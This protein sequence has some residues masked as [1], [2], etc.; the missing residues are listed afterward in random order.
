MGNRGIVFVASI[1]LLA[2]AGCATHQGTHSVARSTESDVR[3]I[4]RDSSAVAIDLP[5]QTGAYVLH[6][7]AKIASAAI[8]RLRGEP[9]VVLVEPLDSQSTK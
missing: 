7:P 4:L 3:R 5:A 2:L 6:V 9:N 1:A 8:L